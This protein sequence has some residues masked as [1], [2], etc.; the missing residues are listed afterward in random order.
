MC[1]AALCVDEGDDGAALFATQA[2]SGSFFLCVSSDSLSAT[3]C[4]RNPRHGC[5]PPLLA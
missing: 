5:Q 2:M 3:L 1:D 4:I